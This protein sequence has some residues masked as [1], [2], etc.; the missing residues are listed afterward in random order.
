MRWSVLFK[1]ATLIMAATA[2]PVLAQPTPGQD[3]PAF[4]L[5]G[6]DGKS[7]ELARLKNRPM[8]V[9]YFFEVD[10]KP[11]QE[12]LISLDRLAKKYSRANMQGWGI[13]RSPREKV[14]DF[15]SRNSIGIPILFDASDVSDR[16]QARVILPTVCILGPGLKV[17]DYLQGGGASTQA[18]LVR[19]AERNLQ[20]K[21]F[22]VAKA[23]SDEI[24]QK[25]P[26][27]LPAKV[28]KGYASLKEGDLPKAK[29]VF[30]EIAQTPGQGSFIAKEGLAEVYAREGQSDKALE[31][32]QQVEQQAPDRGYVHIIKGNILYAK[33]QKAAAESEFRRA[34]EKR[35][36]SP[37]QRAEA[38]NQLGRLQASAGKIKAARE[39]YDQ[40]VEI[41]PYYIEA[42]SNKGITYEK[43]GRFDQA[44][45][46]Y[47]Q[48]LALDNKDAYAAILARQAQERLS[49][50]QDVERKKRLDSLVKDLAERYRTQ[51]KAAASK[52]EDAW[53]SRPM[54]LSFLDFS[55]K[56]GLPERDGFAT[57]LIANLAEQ[58][59]ASGRVK[60]VERVLVERLFEELNL[61]SSELADPNT[62]LNLGKILAAKIIGTGSLLYL[63][64]ANLVNLRLIDTETSV[65]SK[66]LSRQVKPGASLEKDLFE[67]NREI[68]KTIVKS[69]PLQGYVV[70]IVDGKAIINLGSKQG[71]VLGTTF[72]VLREQEPVTY[73]GKTLQTAPRAV[74]QLKVTQVEPD[75]CYVQMI[76]REVEVRQ[77]DKVREKLEQVQ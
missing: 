11:S 27:N 36:A 49:L 28:V 15:A 2:A 9:L 41:D 51:Q 29:A 39:L 8:T 48:V 42:T 16:Y 43:E 24:T 4:K 32:V 65:I 17:L 3:P 13:T 75:L 37:T 12:G 30:Q 74:T 69:Y 57:V 38:L 76:S 52:S 26:G 70:R 71:V 73:K 54:I 1:L 44:L 33:D 53:T 67:L 20:R 59:N 14:S 55:E 40:A 25:D 62:A 68:L 23:M 5:T 21:E 34:T 60:V 18:M 61:G 77:D 22:A 10:S 7:Y 66:V 6:L 72:D 50:Q 35:T 58:L 45:N 46:S 19:L 63:P 47:R 31:L 56:G 64:A